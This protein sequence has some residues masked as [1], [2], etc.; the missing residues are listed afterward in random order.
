MSWEGRLFRRLPS[1]GDALSFHTGWA[2]AHTPCRFDSDL[3]RHNPSE[4]AHLPNHRTRF[5]SPKSPVKVPGFTLLRFRR[6]LLFQQSRPPAMMAACVT[7]HSADTLRVVGSSAA[8]RE[9]MVHNRSAKMN[10]SLVV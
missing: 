3:R 10:T 6:E 2:G 8:A 9:H 7:R 5:G 4:V 1:G